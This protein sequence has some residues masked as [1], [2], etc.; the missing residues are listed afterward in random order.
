MTQ[1]K[2]DVDF[3]T[4]D[5]HRWEDLCFQV[6]RARNPNVKTIDGSGGDEGIDAYVGDFE[7]PSSIYQFKFFSKGFGKSQRDQIKKSFNAAAALRNGFKWILICN[8]DPSA[9]ALRWF[10]SFRAEHA[11]F[12]IS[13][14]SASEF[15]SW[16]YDVPKIRK[17][18][19]PNYQDSIEEILE[20][21]EHNPLSRINASAR[22]YNDVLC[23]DRFNATITSDGNC[24]T[25]VYTLK[26]GINEDVPLFKLRPLSQE[27]CEALGALKREGKPFKLTSEDVEVIPQLEC[28]G[29]LS[30]CISISAVSE[31][32]AN[33]SYL[34]IYSSDKR[35]E[36]TSLFVELKT[37]REG[38]EIFVRSN[39]EQTNSPVIL[40]LE[41]PNEFVLDVNAIANLKC[42]LKPRYKQ[43]PIKTAHKGVRFLAQLMFSHRLGISEADQDFNEASFS[44]LG[45]IDS[46]VSWDKLESLLG[47]I[48]TV[49]NFFDCNP[50]IDD[51]IDDPDFCNA[52]LVFYNELLNANK[53]IDGTLSF[54]LESYEESVIRK[55]EQQE[56]AA[57]V[58]DK[59]WSGNLFGVD[60]AANVR[61]IARG[62]L[63]CKRTNK[64]LF[65]TVKGKYKHLVAPV[66][67]AI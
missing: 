6:L 2:D 19:F 48:E 20:R 28:L 30:D 64:G 11:D 23:D 1:L 18:Y 25:I 35:E 10:D 56:E 42:N 29:D 16:L 7:N 52:L 33:T 44:L 40:E 55:A 51:S 34:R 60:C 14:V 65:C 8:I 57:F 53:E 9:N 12:D 41:C 62:N 3:N 59:T 50:V 5:A 36:S 45:D 67:N 63:S 31:P 49:C 38:E 39:V 43:L 46:N 24:E 4:L 15:K 17:E 47:R 37:V 22:A 58:I 26:P 61:T 13:L 21:P 66:S 27:G 32:K 54:T